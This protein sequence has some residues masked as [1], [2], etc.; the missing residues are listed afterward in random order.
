MSILDD[1]DIV[2]VKIKIKPATLD[3][4]LEISTVRLEIFYSVLKD[5][6]RTI[7]DGTFTDAEGLNVYPAGE[8]I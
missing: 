8:H 7:E 1:L 3:Y 2:E 5:I 4:Q 6:I